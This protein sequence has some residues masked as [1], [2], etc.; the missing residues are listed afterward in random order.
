MSRAACSPPTCTAASVPGTASRCAANTGPTA[1]APQEMTVEEDGHPVG[2]AT[3]EPG[4]TLLDAGLA[5]G[6]PMPY[7]CTVGNC[8]DCMVKLRSGEVAQN[9]PNCLTPRQK[10]DGYVL[11][12][13][14]CPLSEVTLDITDP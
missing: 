8:G 14:S 7:S 11:T 1:T 2:T 4:R 13:V 5:A 12:C 3:V 10:A 9:E 6:L